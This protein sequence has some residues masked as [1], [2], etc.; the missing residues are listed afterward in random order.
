MKKSPNK[1]REIIKKY[2]STAHISDNRYSKI[3]SEKY[4]LIFKEFS[5]EDKFLLDAGCG[6]GLFYDFFLEHLE[7][8]LDKQSYFLGVDI[9]WNML[10]KFSLKLKKK[11]KLAKHQI[12][13]VL[14]DLENLPFRENVF[15]AL[16]S[17]TSLQN[18]PNIINGINESFRV[19]KDNGG[20][21]F[22][23]LK[24]KLDLDEILSHIKLQVKNL[25]IIENDDLE[26]IILS[27]N[28][29]KKT[30]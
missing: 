25:K 20:V 19:T 4:S 2:D 6:T 13:L 24:K 23:I 5:F 26:D 17:L 8:N 1:K 11:E 18:L 27:F 30:Q 15:H 14:S 29:R 21:K 9:S 22:S 10:K 16:F 28:L 12:C 3:Q 7:D